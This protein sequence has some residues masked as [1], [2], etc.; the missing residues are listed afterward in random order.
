VRFTPTFAFFR[1]G[2]KVDEVSKIKPR[3][4]EDRMWL[5]AGEDRASS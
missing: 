3:D 1:D 5:H 4:F 2:R